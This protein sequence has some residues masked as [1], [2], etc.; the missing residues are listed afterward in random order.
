MLLS[1]ILSIAAGYAVRPAEP[2]VRD[3]IKNITLMDLAISDGQYDML[4]LLLLLLALVVLCTIFSIP[5][6]AFIVIVGA[7]I[8][9][10]GKQVLD[11]I[12]NDRDAG[13]RP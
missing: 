9:V 3:A 4:T 8:G 1:F 5:T 2:M 7:L 6:P 13:G 12:R 11:A 10:F